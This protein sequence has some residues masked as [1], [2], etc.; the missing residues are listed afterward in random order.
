[1]SIKRVRSLW[2]REPVAFLTV[3]QAAV[4]LGT[5]FGLQLSGEQ[6]GA[7]MSFTAAVVGFVTR[8]KVT[9]N[10]PGGGGGGRGVA[11]ILLVL[12]LAGSVA[13]CAQSQQARVRHGLVD[14]DKVAYIAMAAIQDAAREMRCEVTRDVQP[15]LDAA[16]F[17]E[18]SAALVP[19]FDAGEKFT[20][21]LQA[22]RADKGVG[23]MSPAELW[24]LGRALNDLRP[25]IQRVVPAALQGNLLERVGTAQRGALGTIFGSGG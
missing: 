7:I 23:A 25:V 4:A 20:A 5:S 6:V 8:Q 18:F 11:G 16:T 17:K 22:W 13:A 9:P 15:C 12:A 21:A 10:A 14:A 2:D 1:V 24:T 19:V 3:V